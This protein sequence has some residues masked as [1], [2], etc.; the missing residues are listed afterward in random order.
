MATGCGGI[1]FGQLGGSRCDGHSFAVLKCCVMCA[2]ELCLQNVPPSS[3]AVHQPFSSFSSFPSNTSPKICLPHHLP[4]LFPHPNIY[5]PSTS[6]D[7]THQC[8]QQRIQ[9]LLFGH[10]PLGISRE[11]E[12]KSIRML[13]PKRG[14]NQKQRQRN[15]HPQHRHGLG[16]GSIENKRVYP[17]THSNIWLLDLVA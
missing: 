8:S 6:L 3:H 16:D 7:N 14:R 13:F 2:L 15:T 10:H 1:D 11:E 9:V 12:V 4:H 17:F 5:N